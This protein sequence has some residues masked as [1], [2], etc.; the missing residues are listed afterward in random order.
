[1]EGPT[2]DFRSDLGR[3]FLCEAKDWTNPVDVT[4]VHKFGG[5]LRAAKC[6]FGII[7]SR[8]GLSGQDRNRDAERELLKINQEGA[9]TIISISEVELNEIGSGANFF[10]LLRDLYEQE[11]LDLP[12]TSRKSLVK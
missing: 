12:R 7:F 3:Y 4:T 2:F 8:K 9:T 6:P 5:V 10:S 11:H 1:V